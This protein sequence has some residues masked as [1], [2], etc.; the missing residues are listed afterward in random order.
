MLN[1]NIGIG[2]FALTEF[3]VCV[4]KLKTKTI[5]VPISSTE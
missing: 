4:D 1:T 3:P 5:T 2:G